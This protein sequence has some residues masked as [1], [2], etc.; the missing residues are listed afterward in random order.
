MKTIRR[1]F[2]GIGK[3]RAQEDGSTILAECSLSEPQPNR[4]M[5][6]EELLEEMKKDEKLH[7]L[8]KQ[9]SQYEFSHENITLYEQILNF[10]KSRN[11]DIA[12]NICD[13]YLRNTSK[14]NLYL[15][16]PVMQEIINKCQQDGD[17]S[18]YVFDKI[19]AAVA[20]NIIDIISRFRK[21]NL[22]LQYIGVAE[23]DIRRVDSMGSMTPRTP[24]TPRLSI[25]SNDGNMTPRTRT[26]SLLSFNRKQ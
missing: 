8:I 20:E 9:F 5:S 6:E 26:R 4:K 19:E 17:L 3:K 18:V 23:N 7:N 24:R 13:N 1:L 12:L 15:T 22:Y 25:F 11:R 14:L 21:S 10:K 16:Q 2:T